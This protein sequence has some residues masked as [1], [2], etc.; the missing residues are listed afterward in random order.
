MRFSWRWVALLALAFMP[1]ACGGDGETPIPQGIGLQIDESNAAVAGGMAVG[2]AE[3]MS[4]LGDL[5]L[6]FES[7]FTGGSGTYPCGAGEIVA[8]INDVAPVGEPSPGDTATFTFNSCAYTFGDQTLEIRGEL[9]FSVPTATTTQL[10]QVSGFAMVFD[11]VFKDLKFVWSDET[12]TLNGGIR[13]TV[14]S[15][16]NVIV[17]STWTGTLVDIHIQ[18]TPG[19]S[20]VVQIIDFE[21]TERWNGSNNAYVLGFK[22]TMA[23]SRGGSMHFESTTALAGTEPQYPGTG[24]W[25]IEGGNNSRCTYF[26]V[27]PSQVRLQVDKD[28]DGTIDADFLVPWN[29]LLE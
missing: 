23:D 6:G 21:F 2:A 24:I 17:D 19:D 16:D 12:L 9:S 20:Y 14:T 7:I 26:V 11:L 8:V 29:N 22:G 3:F 27:D 4:D 1:L 25:F 5:M 15:A 13:Y 10:A 18:E 28:G